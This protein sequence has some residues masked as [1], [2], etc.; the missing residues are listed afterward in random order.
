MNRATKISLI[1]LAIIIIVCG[2]L[3]IGANGWMSKVATKQVQIQLQALN[4]DTLQV[5]CGDVHIRLLKRKV[6]VDDISF[7]MKGVNLRVEEVAV[8]PISYRKLFRDKTVAIKRVK[9]QDASLDYND[10][11][12][13]LT[14]HADSIYASVNQLSY[15]LIDSTF[16]YNDSVY[17]LCLGS[18]FI[19][20]P[21]GLSKAEVHNLRFEDNGPLNLGYTRYCNSVDK[22]KLADMLKEPVTWIDIELNS[23]S[24]SPINPWK[25][26]DVKSYILDSLHVDVRRLHV[27]RDVRYPAKHP[28]P[29]PQQVLMAIPTHF[30]VLHTDARI[31]KI[32]V[33]FAST[34]VNC[35]Q[36]HLQNFAADIWDI[37][38][39]K[40]K[41][42]RSR[43]HGKIG[44]EGRAK[45][46]FVMHMNS[47]CK[48]DLSLEATNI[49]T[50]NINTFLRPLVG[51]TCDC[52]INHLKTNYSGDSVRA[53]GEFMMLYDGLKVQ[54]HKEDD[55]PYKIVTKNAG[56][57]NS[58]VKTC[59]PKSNP[60]TA[61]SQPRSYKVSWKRDPS[62][63]FPLYAFGPII[64]GVVE[65]M[66]PGIFIHK[67]VHKSKK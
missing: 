36:L 34:N 53:E 33:E 49:Q 41:Q 56:T 32:D 8:G 45:A 35:G 50:N 7:M 15:C 58:F 61:H 10:Q 9:V 44:K 39:I 5:G 57:I 12:S 37:T 1:I 54:V 59:V 16:S 65:T 46:L 63:E 31:H 38:N 43:L 48:F 11:S 4:S 40:G 28:Y 27:Y 2:T 21:D 6:Y 64:N 30:D 42:F 23:L 60:T 19:T 20:L 29:M 47:A 3:I 18:A 25:Y 67:Q 55:I 62:K 24:T 52:N 13:K 17:S 26:V 51:M 66:L 22:H 14:V